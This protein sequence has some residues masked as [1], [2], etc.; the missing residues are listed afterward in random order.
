MLL[1]QS[2]LSPSGVL[3][4]RALDLQFRCE[5][6]TVDLDDVP[7]DEYLAFKVLKAEINRH[8]RQELEKSK[9][10]GPAAPATGYHRR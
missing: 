8:E 6:F 4:D 9:H 3:L 1:R 5:N 10:N 7:A 2:M